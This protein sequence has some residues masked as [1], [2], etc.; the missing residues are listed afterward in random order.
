[1]PCEE[2]VCCCLKGKACLDSW[3]WI[4]LVHWKWDGSG[5]HTECHGTL[6]VQHWELPAEVRFRHV[7][8]VRI[9]TFKCSLKKHWSIH[10]C[11]FDFKSASNIYLLC[12]IGLQSCFAAWCPRTSVQYPRQTCFRSLPQHVALVCYT[13][14]CFV[15]MST[16][17]A[18]EKFLDRFLA[19]PLEQL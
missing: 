7:E 11:L 19:P 2:S 8:R 6:W 12:H 15:T 14:L 1:M 10:S 9:F 16:W 13:W 18:L 17:Q 3:W 4:C 5:G